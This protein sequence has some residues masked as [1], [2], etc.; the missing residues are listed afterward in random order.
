MTI[1]LYPFNDFASY[2]KTNAFQ[3]NSI[4]K[5]GARTVIPQMGNSKGNIVLKKMKT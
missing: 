4:V 5:I 2:K 1:E 3:F